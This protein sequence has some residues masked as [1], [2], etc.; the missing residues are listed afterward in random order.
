MKKEEI[1][2]RVIAAGLTA[3]V[4][5]QSAAREFAKTAEAASEEELVAALEIAERELGSAKGGKPLERNAEMLAKADG[6]LDGWKA[7]LGPGVLRF[8]KN[9]LPDLRFAFGYAV[10]ID[11]L[12]PRTPDDFSAEMQ[13]V[14]GRDEFRLD[15]GAE[16][17]SAAEYYSAVGKLLSCPKFLSGLSVLLRRHC[18]ALSSLRNRREVLK[19]EIEKK[20]TGYKM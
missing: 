15:S 17:A 7:S 10:A 5:D 1:S 18:D 11:R 6:V 19:A 8:S 2:K 14:A 13:G 3:E 16:V 4:F 9:G 12:T 20:R